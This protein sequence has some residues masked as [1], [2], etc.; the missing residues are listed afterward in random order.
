MLTLKP[1]VQLSWAFLS[2]WRRTTQRSSGQDYCCE[3]RLPPA[4]S[5]WD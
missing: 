5:D 2:T 4:I 3:I 1:T